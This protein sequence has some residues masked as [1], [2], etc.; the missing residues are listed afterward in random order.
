MGNSVL[1]VLAL[2]AIALSILYLAKVLKVKSSESSLSIA[3]E[4]AALPS[5][6]VPPSPAQ[7]F[8]K[9]VPQ[10]AMP[11]T[12]GRLLTAGSVSNPPEPGGYIVDSEISEVTPPSSYRQFFNFKNQYMYTTFGPDSFG[13]IL[14]PWK[15]G[16]YHRSGYW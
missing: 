11:G 12:A 8:I 16:F 15:T 5:I 6:M 9:D 7:A 1:L 3:S 4:P 10:V 13:E 2:I 14:Y